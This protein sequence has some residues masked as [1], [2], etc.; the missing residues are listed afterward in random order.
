[1]S[2]T[3]KFISKFNIIPKTLRKVR[4]ELYVPSDIKMSLKLS[5]NIKIFYYIYYILNIKCCFGELHFRQINETG[6]SQE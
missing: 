5:H 3:N 6:E 1:M 2:I 4:Q